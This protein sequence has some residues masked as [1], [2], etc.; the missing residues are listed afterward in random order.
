MSSL[1]G[2]AV[3]VISG[4]ADKLGIDLP[5]TKKDIN[6]SPIE[7][8]FS[9]RFSGSEKEL[10]AIDGQDW[11]KVFGYQFV[12]EKKTAAPPA[13]KSSGGGL[14]DA[15]K[16][17]VAKATGVDLGGATA[18]VVETINYTLPI[19]PQQFIAKPILANRVTPT[20]GGVVEETSPVTFWMISM[21][22]TTGTGIGRQGNSDNDFKQIAGK[23]RQ[24]ISTTGL[25]SGIAQEANSIINKVGNL[26][27]QIS[28]GGFGNVIGAVNNALTPPLPYSGSG[29]DPTSN[30][31]T[32]IQAFQKFIYIYQKLKSN[33]PSEYNLYFVNHKTN[34]KWRIVVKDFVIQQSAQ[35]PNLYRYNVQLQGWD[36]TN[37]KFSGDRIQFDRFGPNG[38]LKEVNTTNVFDTVDKMKSIG[39]NIFG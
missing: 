5:T 14:F 16:S 11:Y 17:A 34:Q 15:A 36:I 2:K 6:K 23:F 8:E 20:I 22:G 7:N 9:A 35:N 19:P 13:K 37:A 31:F 24:N 39:R 28:Q 25:L 26:A 33:Y 30:G 38:D 4:A 18:P 29:V 1:L 12:I 32:E 27:D 3:D 10:W 21:A